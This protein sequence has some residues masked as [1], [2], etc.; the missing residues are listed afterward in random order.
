MNFNF[1]EE[2]NLLRESISKFV[3]N[4]YDFETRRDIIDSETGFS[5]N[6]WTQFSELGWLTVPF[7][8]SVGGFG[9][10]PID[11][12]IVMEELGKGLVVEPYVSTVLLAGK[13]IELGANSSVKEDLLNE[14]MTG[15]KFGALAYQERQSRFNPYNVSCIAETDGDGFKLTG[16]KSVVIDGDKAD[17]IIV[18]AR[19]SGGQLDKAGI[20]LFLVDTKDSDVKI[21][22][23][24][25][26][27]GTRAAEIQLDNVKVD[28]NALLGELNQGA[29]L[30]E[31]VINHAI[32]AVCAEMVGALGVIQNST[33][34]YSKTRKQFGTAI[35]SFQA[36]QH[37]LAE[38]FME[39]EQCKSL[40][41]RAALS[42]QQSE[43]GAGEDV[44]KDIAALKCKLGEAGVF[45]AQDAVQ[46]HGGMGLTD[47][48]HIGHYL[49]RV[50]MINNQFG[51][52]DYHKQKFA[53]LI[54]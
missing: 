45:I 14:I 51:N 35:G 33:V 9:G 52:S 31:P 16:S 24:K 34:E 28:K 27:D 19:T 7:E 40:L 38:M 46:L 10:G 36:L 23:L 50:L 29:E 20:S 30:L 32:L 39:Y 44:A 6:Y 54:A 1:S 18:T 37:R 41:Y 43:N 21:E 47:E 5:T 8:E 17:V 15:E 12:M 49:K 2:Q 26:M 48:L 11:T 13:L 25:M 22:P 4:D 53:D 42:L 3:Q